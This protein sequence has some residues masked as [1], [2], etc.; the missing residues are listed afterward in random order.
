[1]KIVAD[2]NLFIRVLLEDDVAQAAAARAVLDRA[3]LIAIP[4]PVLCEMA[5]VLARLYRLSPSQIA[6][7]IEGFVAATG[8]LTDRP[9]VEL[10]LAF[11]RAG[12][13]FADGA[14]AAQGLALG[15]ETFVSFDS[16]AVARCRALGLRAESPA[17]TTR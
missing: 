7:A 12:G 4:V 5:W 8:V 6:D 2:T 16:R 17:P 1:M 14:I 9:A 11:A 3:S 10:G 15:A 13:G